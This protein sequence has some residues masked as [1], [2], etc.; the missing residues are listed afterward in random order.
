[1][2]FA[3]LLAVTLQVLLTA[4]VGGVF[5]VSYATKDIFLV[6][7]EPKPAEHLFY[8]EY[9]ELMWLAG[10]QR[11]CTDGAETQRFFQLRHH[12]SEMHSQTSGAKLF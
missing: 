2:D 1:L 6:E 12:W 7:E 11:Q 10:R 5:L 9:D 4:G 3:D 8:S